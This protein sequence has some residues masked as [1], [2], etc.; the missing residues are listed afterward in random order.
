LN[1][2]AEFFGMDAQTLNWIINGIF[3]LFLALG[4]AW[5]RRKNEEH[6]TEIENV[7]TDIELRKKAQEADTK[8]R[9]AIIDLLKAQVTVTTK[10]ADNYRE[11]ADRRYAQ[12]QQRHVLIK[13][14]TTEQSKTI[15]AVELLGVQIGKVHDGVKEAGSDTQHARA[16]VI[17]VDKS[18]ET[19][20]I[21]ISKLSNTLDD[22]KKDV[23]TALGNLTRD[24]LASAEKLT[25]QPIAEDIRKALKDT[26]RTILQQFEM[27][28]TEV[29]KPIVITETKTDETGEADIP[30]LSDAVPSV[31]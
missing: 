27:L 5:M 13:E 25:Q 6:A 16:L 2:L 11:D 31:E 20:T 14:F 15:N 1:E 9:Q 24:V 8:E 28:K 3:G 7:R 21:E 4:Y 26:E 19:L 30:S 29:N 10:M 22:V 23:V 12:E 17:E 18:V